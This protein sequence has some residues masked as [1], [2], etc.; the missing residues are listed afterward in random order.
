MK[1][2][3]TR[4]GRAASCAEVLLSCGCATSSSSCSFHGSF[5][6]LLQF[7]AGGVLVH[8]LYRPLVSIFAGLVCLVR[9]GS[10]CSDDRSCKVPGQP[11]SLG[12]RCMPIRARSA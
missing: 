7:F 10:M 5:H 8:Y 9:V 6:C 11:A 2:T 12:L 1:R 4:R 3:R